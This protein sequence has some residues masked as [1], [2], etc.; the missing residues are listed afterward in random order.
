[1]CVSQGKLLL[2]GFAFR[3]R[4]PWNSLSTHKFLYW[5]CKTGT[6]G[7]SCWGKCPSVHNLKTCFGQPV[8]PSIQPQFL[9]LHFDPLLLGVPPKHTSQVISFCSVSALCMKALTLYSQVPPSLRCS[10]S[11]ICLAVVSLKRKTPYIL[12]AAFGLYIP[13]RLIPCHRRFPTREDSLELTL[14]YTLERFAIC[15]TFGV[16]YNQNTTSPKRLYSNKGKIPSK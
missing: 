9:L 13:A 6:A 15:S 16:Q 5:A 11:Y 3:D 2:P 1:M 7:Q 12:Q 10:T 8:S 14:I 4:I